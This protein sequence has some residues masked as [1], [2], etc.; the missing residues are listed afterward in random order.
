MKTSTMT[1]IAFLAAFL[2]LTGTQGCYTQLGITRDEE[3]YDDDNDT[4]AVAEDEAAGE[5]AEEEADDDADANGYGEDWDSN[6][7]FGF[8]YY[9]PYTY[10]PSVT[11]GMA[12]NDPWYNWYGYNSWYSPYYP[13]WYNH[14]PWSPYYSNYGYGYGYGYGYYYPG[15]YYQNV[16]P[17]PRTNRDFGSTRGSRGTGGTRGVNASDGMRGGI[18]DPQHMDLPSASGRVTTGGTS[19]GKPG[20]VKSGENSRTTGS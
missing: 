15:Y 10:W 7:R 2:T 13:S 14:R 1:L 3:A 12:Y 19:A 18:N 9:Y 11:F 20:S 8:D 5:A 17:V 16:A 4:E 6:V